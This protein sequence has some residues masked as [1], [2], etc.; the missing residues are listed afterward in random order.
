MAA[1]AMKLAKLLNEEKDLQNIHDSLI[2]A[3]GNVILGI[4]NSKAEFVVMHRLY[5]WIKHELVKVKHDKQKL[6][7]INLIWDSLR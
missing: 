5:M 7:D 3:K 6:S 1:F 4:N 2:L